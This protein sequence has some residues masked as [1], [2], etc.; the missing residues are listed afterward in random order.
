MSREHRGTIFLEEGRVLKQTQFDGDQYVIRIEAPKC[1]AHA[2]PGS[3]AHITC[4]VTIPMRRP[5]SLM[6]VDAQAG[7][8][9]L[10]R[11]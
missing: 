9:S 6:R 8:E 10:H 4:D 7:W 3:F 2:Q 5:L 1:A 11:K